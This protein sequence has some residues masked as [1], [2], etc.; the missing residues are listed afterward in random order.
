M[1]ALACG[2]TGQRRR[3]QGNSWLAMAWEATAP[4]RL[5]RLNATVMSKHSSG[6]PI[7]DRD[8]LFRGELAALLR[9]AGIEPVSR[10]SLDADLRPQR[11][12]GSHRA[13]DHRSKGSTSKIVLIGESHLG[14][15]IDE[16]AADYPWLAIIKAS[17]NSRSPS[18]ASSA[19]SA[20]AA[21]CGRTTGLRERLTPIDIAPTACRPI[22][23]AA[24]SRST[25][26]LALAAAR[27][28]GIADFAN[29][30]SA[31]E[32]NTTGSPRSSQSLGNENSGREEEV[33]AHRGRCVGIAIIGCAHVRQAHAASIMQ[34][35]IHSDRLANQVIISRDELCVHRSRIRSFEVSLLHVIQR[36]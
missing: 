30:P 16:F 29:R 20:W 8:P 9:S 28:V 12:A 6:D 15:A 23:A 3:G 2:R 36:V 17:G 7:H 26:C 21:S 4:A 1:W 33:S 5:G 25:G 24:R 10:P 11:S 19:A 13:V 14:C 22:A 31:E 27:A 35:L 32:W 18:I 34:S